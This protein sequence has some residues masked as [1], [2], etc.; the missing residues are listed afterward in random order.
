MKLVSEEMLDPVEESR[1]AK[2]TLGFIPQYPGWPWTIMGI[3]LTGTASTQLKVSKRPRHL[4][5]SVRVRSVVG[6][7]YQK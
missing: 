7:D 5:A 3:F 4:T 2:T 1:P 6:F